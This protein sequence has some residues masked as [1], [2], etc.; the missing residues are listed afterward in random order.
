M[1]QLDVYP[2]CYV[3]TNFVGHI[4][5]GKVKHKSPCNEVAKA[6]NNSDGFAIGIIDDDKRRA[7]MDAG[8]YK[9]CPSTPSDHIT[10]FVHRDGKRFMFTINPAM[11]KFIMDAAKAQS[12]DLKQ[13]G[14]SSTLAGFKKETKR[15]QAAEDSNLRKLF[16]RIEEYPE[17]Q[18]FKNTL[19]YLTKKQYSADV[20]IA[21]KFFNGDF[22]KNKLI[23][24]LHDY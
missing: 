16:S 20:E 7:T 18:R 21:K 12:V 1:K 22:D 9:I 15:V 24:I 14:F 23:D 6:V 2:E 4:L 3:D 11:D 13:F 10:M 5:G 17:I 8:F 19:R